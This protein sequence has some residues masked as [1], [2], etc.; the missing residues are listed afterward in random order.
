M[1]MADTLS[2]AYLKDPVYDDPELKYV[3]HSLSKHLPMSKEKKDTFQ[4]ETSNDPDLSLLKQFFHN[5]WPDSKNKCPPNVRLYYNLRDKITVEE[6]LVF[7]DDKL[8][9]PTSLRNFML[10]LIHESHLGIEKCKARA[11]EVAYWPGMSNQIHEHV[12]KCKV[13]EKFRSSNVKQP[14]LSHPT[15][16]RPWQKLAAD[17]FQFGPYDYLVVTDYYSRWI[18]FFTLSGKTANDVIIKLKPLFARFGIPET[19]I[20]DNMPF[21]SVEFLKFAHD[22]D[23]EVVTSSPLYPRSNGLAEKS[24]SVAKSMLRKSYESACD[25]YV[26]L[27]EYRN[28]PLKDVGVSPAQLMLNRRIKTKIP[29]NTNMLAPKNFDVDIKDKLNAKIVQSKQYY[30]KNCKV[31]SSNFQVN[32]PV[33]IQKGN[34]WEPGRIRQIYKTPRSYVVTQSNGRDVRRNSIHLRKSLNCTPTHNPEP[35]LQSKH[36]HPPMTENNK[37]APQTQTNPNINP[38]QPTTRYGRTI[39]KPSKL[40]L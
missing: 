36:S 6:N 22:Y 40:D 10:G 23:F 31:R 33:M 38:D 20:S 18:E 12:L 11:R 5:G 24:V 15:P 9:V 17:I 2:R 28:T 4:N 25:V 19:F 14:M 32:D 3:V 29:T 34:V 26:S 37:N 16:D 35:E 39:K 27:M 13:C 8:I 7:L 21:S 30:D 1:F